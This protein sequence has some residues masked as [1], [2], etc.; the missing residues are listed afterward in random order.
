MY[1]SQVLTQYTSIIYA[2]INTKHSRMAIV[3]NF[4]QHTDSVMARPVPL[5]NVMAA[6]F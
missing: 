2:L 3:G 4:T 5:N 6:S 1:S